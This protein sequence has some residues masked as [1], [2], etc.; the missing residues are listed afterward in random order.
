MRADGIYERELNV[1]FGS[2]LPDYTG[3]VQNT[4]TIFKNFTLNINI[5]YSVGG[6]YFSL[7]DYYG[8][9]TGLYNNSTGLN[10]KG[11]PVRDLV[12]NGGGTHVFG[13]DATGKPVDY[14]VETR[15]FWEQNGLYSQGIAETAIRDLGFVKLRELGLGYTLP[16]AKLGIGKYVKTAVFTIL[17][18]NPWLIYAKGGK[19]FDPSELSDNS[20][21]TGALPGTRGLGINLKL[22][23]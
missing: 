3:G 7:S 16:M 13:V 21:E 4:F 10:D 5:D 19:G 23:F 20:G 18:R 8:S 1:N 12:A 11:I 9:S 14:Y 6:K 15:Y 17:A 22:G 2:S